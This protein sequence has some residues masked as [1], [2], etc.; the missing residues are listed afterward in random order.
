MALSL[1]ARQARWIDY[2]GRNAVAILP[3]T[4]AQKARQAALVMWWALKEGVLDL[5]NPIRHNLC[6]AA[7][8]VQI[9]D[10]GV[11]P[12]GAW[13]I[14]ISGIQG[15]V[16]SDAQV[17]AM[18]RRVHPSETA[19]QTLA[20]VADLADVDNRTRQAII[21]S[22]STTG[23]L[24]RAWLLRDPAIAIAL[25]A[26]FVEACLRSGAP[27]WCYGGWDTARQFASSQA[28]I[29]EVIADLETRYAS[30]ARGG[31]WLP[32]LLLAA[33]VGLVGYGYVQQH[34]WPQLT[35]RALR[36]APA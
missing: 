11:C 20:R 29:R 4:P 10:L 15:N 27:S 25:Q 26:P 22:A 17:E 18:R 16:V 7:G 12:S 32:W 5:P 30:S 19:A 13:Q 34:G 2:V 6:T 36:P 31:S 8:E 28:R 35:G 3:G 24:R 21:D 9:G 1:N 33:G 23:P 14:G